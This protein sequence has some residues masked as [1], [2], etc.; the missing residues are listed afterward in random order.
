MGV[1]ALP[2]VGGLV[3]A[4]GIDHARERVAAAVRERARERGDGALGVGGG[5]QHGADGVHERRVPLRP[6]AG[7]ALG[8][9]GV[10][11]VVALEV[12]GN[13][14]AA[15]EFGGHGGVD[16]LQ[17]AP[18]V[19]EGLLVR[20]GRAAAHVER[21]VE[22]Q[23]V[24]VK[25]AQPHARVVHEV[26]ADF[27]AAVVG[28]GV[29]PGR[30]AAVVVVEVD[31][32]AI[33][34]APPV[35][36]P[37]VEVGGAEVVV[38]HVHEHRHAARVGLAHE[39]LEGIGAAVGAL[40]GERMG[41]VVAPRDVARKL[42]HRHQPDS[43]DAEALEVVE[44]FPCLLGERPR[45][46]LV[47][48]GEGLAEEG[49]A[50][51]LV[52]EERIPGRRLPGVF[53]RAP[54]EGVVVVDARLA[55]RVGHLPGV[56]VGAPERARVGVEHELVG[57]ARPHAGHERGPVAGLVFARERRAVGRPVAERARDAHGGRVR[58]PHAERHAA[59]DRDGAHPPMRRR[60]DGLC[61]A[62]VAGF[63]VGGGVAVRG[64]GGFPGRTRCGRLG[65]PGGHGWV[66]QSG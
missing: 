38:D 33:V 3:V 35:E 24:H 52:D 43:G 27:R 31:A 29:A 53:L 61:R 18:A 65:G 25:A 55:D 48:R 2:A 34:L 23:A 62:L 15:G 54:V 39:G 46:G 14:D 4:L 32:A 30:L 9:G 21:H 19:G 45:A 59:F 5:L 26:G 58:R 37:Q 49:A 8:D 22:A 17:G 47:L 11:G 20:V 28:A 6:E 57:I 56:G 51:H 13:R 42:G 7:A 10:E 60:G 12:L 1:E 66:R 16:L 40:D 50:V 63:S 44:A 36:A 41:R 64:R